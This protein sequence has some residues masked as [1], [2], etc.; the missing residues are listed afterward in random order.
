MTTRTKSARL[1]SAM[2]WLMG[3]LFVLAG[4]Y[5]FVNPGFYVRL[6]PPYLP[7]HLPLVYLSGLAE[8]AL[9][10]ALMIAA[11]ARFAAWGIVALLV[12]FLSVH[13]HMVV[14]HHLYPEVHVA[15][16]WVRLAMQ[17]LLIGWAYWFTK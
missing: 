14:N 3:I 10:G 5:H 11:S 17:G 1:K 7:W 12:S 15:A 16:L 2:R 9:G 13:V 4:V 6:M 8:I